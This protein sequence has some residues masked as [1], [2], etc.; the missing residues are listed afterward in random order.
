M[1][2]TE[3]RIARERVERQKASD[4]R[5]IVRQVNTGARFTNSARREEAQSRFKEL[6]SPQQTARKTTTPQSPQAEGTSLE[7]HVWKE[8]ELGII[9]L[10]QLSPFRSL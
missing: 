5:D 10:S 8:G 4:T 9:E 7:L 2:T 6:L 1:E 3:Q